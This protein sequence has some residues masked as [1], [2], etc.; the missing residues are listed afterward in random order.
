MG[1]P[2][3]RREKPPR[4]RRNGGTSRRQKFICGPRDDL[5]SRPSPSERCTIKISASTAVLWMGGAVATC[6]S[7]FPADEGDRGTVGIRGGNE[8]AHLGGGTTAPA[9]T[10]KPGERI[11]SIGGGSHPTATQPAPGHFCPLVPS[12]RRSSRQTRNPPTVNS[13]K[14]PSA[15]S[16]RGRCRRKVGTADGKSET[17]AP[18]FT[19][20]T[21]V[22][23]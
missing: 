5:R 21:T 11:G 2:H 4:R 3:P 23:G 8:L 19:R 16:G 9:T 13:P 22:I 6:V 7:Q 10:W 17:I 1:Q 18:Y 20:I 14:S 12:W 15:T